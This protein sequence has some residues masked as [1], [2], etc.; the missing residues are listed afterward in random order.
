MSAEISKF[1]EQNIK[2]MVVAKLVERL[3][4][5]P[6]IRCSSPVIGNFFTV[7]F[8]ELWSSG[9]GRRLMIQRSWVRIPALYTGWT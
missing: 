7:N 4:R 6:E 9:Y 1:S 5:T 8:I 3:L 2:A